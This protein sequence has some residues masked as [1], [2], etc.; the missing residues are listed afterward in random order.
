MQRALDVGGAGGDEHGAAGRRA[1]VLGQRRGVEAQRLAAERRRRR[2]RGRP[3]AARARPTR[4]VGQQPGAERERARDE[5]PAP[6]EHLDRRAGG[7]R[8]APRARPARSAAAGAETLSRATSRPAGAG[9]VERRAQLMGDERCA[10]PR[11][12]RARRGRAER[13][14]RVSR[15]RQRAR[16]HV[17][18]MKPTPRTVWMS[19]G[20]PSLRAQPRDVAVDHVGHRRLLP[21]LLDRALAR[22][23]AARVAQQQ[24]EQRALARGELDRAPAARG[25]A[26]R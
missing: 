4:V 17:R 9:A 16:P 20:S 23:D 22:D 1:A 21:D 10:R 25:G 14:G 7:R 2:S 18:S 15:P 3:G 5:A 11:T 12:G 24:L 26:R 19:G 6:V 8:R 13:R